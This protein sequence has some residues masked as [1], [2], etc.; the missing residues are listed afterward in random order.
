MSMELIAPSLRLEFREFCVGLVLRQIDDI[1]QMA[2][3]QLGAIPE[4]RNINGERRSR[5]EEYYATID[6]VDPIFIVK[7]K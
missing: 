2:E 1:F 6:S 5:V 3:I 7:A 4:N